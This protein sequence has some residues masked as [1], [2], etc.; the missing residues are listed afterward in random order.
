MEKK[1]ACFHPGFPG[2]GGKK[3]HKR[4]KKDSCVFS[5]RKKKYK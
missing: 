2:L 4:K 5:A 1:A 3:K